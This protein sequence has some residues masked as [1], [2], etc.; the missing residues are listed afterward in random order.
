MLKTER[1]QLLFG[2][3]HRFLVENSV[4]YVNNSA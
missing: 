4:E 3:N 2:V 1:F